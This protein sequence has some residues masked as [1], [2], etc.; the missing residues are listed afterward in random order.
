MAQELFPVFSVFSATERV[1]IPLS[2]RT[3]LLRGVS[4]IKPI[5]TPPP[6]EGDGVLFSLDFFL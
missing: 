2:R 6:V 5:I 4:I 1:D 3:N